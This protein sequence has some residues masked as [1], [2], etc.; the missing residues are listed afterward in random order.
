MVISLFL[1]S[2]VFG[3]ILFI[4][5]VWGKIRPMVETDK[6]GVIYHAGKESVIVKKK[7]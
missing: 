2:I 4:G 5:K 3:G 6:D 7:A 1:M